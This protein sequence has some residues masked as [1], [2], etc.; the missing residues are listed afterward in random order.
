MEAKT[1]YN[2]GDKVWT[3]VNGKEEHIPIA[4]VAVRE[5]KAVK[6]IL[7]E[8]ENEPTKEDVVERKEEYLLEHKTQQV[9]V[10]DQLFDSQ[11]A[12]HLETGDYTIPAT[13]ER[14]VRAF[15]S[16]IQAI[17][18]RKRLEAEQDKKLNNPMTISK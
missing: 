7:K 3:L 6:N 11:Q 9:R 1:K 15:K 10:L 13:P 5:Y 4:A 18:E 14:V 2:V 16:D 12:L 17:E 8:G